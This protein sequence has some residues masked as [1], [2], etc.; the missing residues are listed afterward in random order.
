MSDVSRMNAAELS[1]ALRDLHKALI[2]AEA[3]DDPAYSNPYTLLFDVIGNPRFAWLESLS[4]LIVVLDEARADKE[5]FS[6]AILADAARSAGRLIGEGEEH[7]AQFRLRHLMAVQSTPD[8]AIA[9][10]RLRAVLA[11]LK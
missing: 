8:V 10:G 9:T 6:N 1:T 11:R 2:H 3:G 7:D 4:Q 5:A